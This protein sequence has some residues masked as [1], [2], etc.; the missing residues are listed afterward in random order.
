[1][2]GFFGGYLAGGR[3]GLSTHFW[4]AGSCN[5]SSSQAGQTYRSR[6]RPGDSEPSFIALP[7]F[8]HRFRIR[9]SSDIWI[10]L[11]DQL[12]AATSARSREIGE[13]AAANDAA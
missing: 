5:G 2:T 3:S 10:S 11:P 4:A 6:P 8:G 13:R 1:M 9:C 7:Q 12:S